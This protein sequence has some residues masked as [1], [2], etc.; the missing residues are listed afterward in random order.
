MSEVCVTMKYTKEFFRAPRKGKAFAGESRCEPRYPPPQPH[1]R[2][3]LSS[4]RGASVRRSRCGEVDGGA[5]CEAALEG[6]SWQG[7]VV[8]ERN[9]GAVSEV[10]A[11]FGAQPA[12]HVLH[13][14]VDDVVR[15][16]GEGDGAALLV[17]SSKRLDNVLR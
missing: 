12:L 17:T 7:A 3:V 6:G 1:S 2:A 10:R 16:C 8:E 5:C 14:D 4:R 11:E 15:S 9:E 13:V